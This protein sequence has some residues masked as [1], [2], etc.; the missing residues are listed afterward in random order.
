MAI[1][2]MWDVLKDNDLSKDMKAVIIA[3]KDRKGCGK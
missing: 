1:S 3:S 2:R